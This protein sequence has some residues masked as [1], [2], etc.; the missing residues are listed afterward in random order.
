MRVNDLILCCAVWRGLVCYDI[1]LCVVLCHCVVYYGVVRCDVV[2]C[3]VEM[4]GMTRCDWVP[5]AVVAMRLRFSRCGCGASAVRFR[6]GR[7]AVA[8][9]SRCGH[10]PVAV[11]SRCPMLSRNGRGRGAV[12]VVAVR[13]RG[14]RGAVVVR[15]RCDCGHKAC[16]GRFPGQVCLGAVEVLA[17]CVL[18]VCCH[19]CGGGQ[20][21]LLLGSAAL[22][23]LHKGLS[24]FYKFGL[25]QDSRACFRLRSVDAAVM[26]C[27]HVPGSL[28]RR[29]ISAMEEVRCCIRS[30]C[31]WV[32]ARRQV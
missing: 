26:A 30:V 1:L 25:H 19:G 5:V 16:F 21:S 28:R 22:P 12:A 14:F 24:W 6:F 13:S 8:V 29:D 2:C 20:P 18:C 3:V 23:T 27:P 32:M 31:V 4:C 7:G 15:S 9:L 10:G 11:R 17:L